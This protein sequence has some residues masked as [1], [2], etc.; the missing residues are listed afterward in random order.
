MNRRKFT[1]II[2]IISFVIAEV[3]T[4]LLLTHQI[5]WSWVIYASVAVILGG[6]EYGDKVVSIFIKRIIAKYR[7][8]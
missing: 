3:I 1:I 2:S 8:A 6:L 5:H 7:N 4:A